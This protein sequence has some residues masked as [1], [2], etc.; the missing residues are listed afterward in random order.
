MAGKIARNYRDDDFTL[1]IV[2]GNLRIGKSAYSIKNGLSVLD[3]YWGD[4]P[5]WESIKP[6]MGWHPAEVVEK[7]LNVEEREPFFIWDDAGMWLYSLDWHNPLM[8]AIQKYMN[9][10]ATDYS[11]LILTTPS[12]KWILSKI[13]GMP[14][15][16]RV[17]II[18]RYGTKRSDRESR[19]FSRIAVSYEPWNSP[20][21]KKHGVY[22]RFYDKYS[23][24]LPDEL[25]KVYQPI[26]EEYARLAKM[27]IKNQLK[28]RSTIGRLENMRMDARLRR[29]Q[30]EEEKIEADLKKMLDADVQQLT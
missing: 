4:P 14:G 2:E 26:R 30:K 22:K 6:Y 19:K 10:I 23:C 21:L 28:L 11:N 15:M 13:A 1:W 18:K 8:V 9:V 29:L 17:K 3:Y 12:V 16:Q 27:E 25:Y 20:D 24:K 5:K 7:W